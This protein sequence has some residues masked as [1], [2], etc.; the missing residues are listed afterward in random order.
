MPKYC[1]KNKL[2]Y[3]VSTLLKAHLM[4]SIVC[5]FTGMIGE[6]ARKKISNRPT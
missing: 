6:L 3:D 1:A 2:F 4:S 5:K